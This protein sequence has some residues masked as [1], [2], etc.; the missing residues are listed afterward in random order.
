MPTLVQ[1]VAYAG[2][3]ATLGL[4]LAG[5]GTTYHMGDTIQAKPEPASVRRPD[6]EPKPAPATNTYRNTSAAN[7][8]DRWGEDWKTIQSSSDN[9]GWVDH[10]HV[11]GLKYRFRHYDEL[12]RCLDLLD[13]KIAAG[14]ARVSE[15]AMVQRGTPAL[16]DWL[17]ATAY[18]E[19]GDP[20][21]ALKWAELS[22][23]ALP[24]AYRQADNVVLQTHF[25]RGT[26]TDIEAAA[27]VGMSLG[28][29]G[30]DT[31]NSD[32]TEMFHQGRNNPAALDLRPPMISM[33][34]A[35]Q[36]SLLYQTLG[37]QSESDA[38]LA[39]LR[40]WE[41]THPP[42][43]FN[44]LPASQRPF[45]GR[46]QMLAIGPLYAR[47]NYQRVANTYEVLS[48]KYAARRREESRSQS[49]S[50]AL[51]SP[52]MA[53]QKAGTALFNKALYPS[54]TRLFAVAV[55]DVGNALLY[56]QSLLQLGRVDAARSML[57]TLLAMPEIPAMGNLYWVALYERGRIALQAGDR[58]QGIRLLSQSVGAIEAARSSISFEAAKIGFAGDKQTV[59]AVLIGALAGAGDWTRAFEYAERAK[60][61]ALVDL[62]AERR[63]LAPPPTPDEKV[64]ALFAQAAT[65]ERSMGLANDEERQRGIQ[66]VADARTSLAAAA[67]QAASLLSVQQ[68][69]VT[70]IT[71]RL[72]AGD[73]LVEYFLAGDDLYAFVVD[74][75]G[76]RG[77]KLQGKGLEADVRAFRDAITMTACCDRC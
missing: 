42:G 41:E 46:A 12:F 2:R 53:L 59:Y 20:E 76:V 17:R 54:D 6:N 16:T 51:F 58:D 10:F 9:V 39:D 38:A 62:L 27:Y 57:D 77:M 63:N 8:A 61:R 40:R 13:A 19:L 71:G 67:P 66:V 15:A 28:S 44:S 52:F 5:C 37:R 45:K 56:T 72:T 36:R 34:L 35:V 43:G 50:W 49:V 69:P 73:R 25:G 3:V 4:L 7:R 30:F 65:A 75:Q 60:A 29:M 68:V 1:R 48:A 11:C 22:W 74:G 18:A 21:T 33:S 23:Q 26:G 31:G 64:R 55:E 32:L 24:E 70:Q 47:G 14:G